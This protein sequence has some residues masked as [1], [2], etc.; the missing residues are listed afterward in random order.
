MKERGLTVS[1]VERQAQTARPI[2]ASLKRKRKLQVKWKSAAGNEAYKWLARMF[3]CAA[4]E[5]EAEA[6]RQRSKE[7]AM[8]PQINVKGRAQ[9]F[10]PAPAN[11]IL[12]NY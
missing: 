4:T 5:A 8:R 1:G 12:M 2:K 11:E 6:K 7:A 3:S 9:R 10:P